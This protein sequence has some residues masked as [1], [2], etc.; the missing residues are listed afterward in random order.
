MPS[1]IAGAAFAPLD[2]QRR[3]DLLRRFAELRSGREKPGRFWRID[4]EAI[5]VPQTAAAYTPPEIRTPAIR[6]G[7]AMDILRAA[8]EHPQLFARAFGSAIAHGDRKFAALAAASCNTGAFVYVPAG[9]AVDEPVEI[10]YDA[11]NGA[12]FPYTLVLAERGS[13]VTI[14]EQVR[15]AQRSFVC[16]IDEVAAGESA[17]VTFA[18][19]QDL[20]D[21]ATLIYTRDASPRKDAG[22]TWSVAHLGAHLTVDSL[23]VH[24]GQPGVEAAINALFF[25]GG[26]QHVDL[27]STATHDAGD[28]RS[29][30]LIKSAGTGSGQG[31]YVGNIRIAAHAQATESG[32]RDDALLLSKHAHIDSVPALEIAANDVK[33]FHGATVGAIDEEQIFYMISRGIAREDAEKMIALGFFEPVVE[34]FPTNAL[35]EMLRRALEAK[36]L[37]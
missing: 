25:P 16:G 21:D 17:A 22:V 23:D 10:V 9:V 19:Y 34:R 1:A 15:G 32:L 5:A 29:Q 26:T 18:A 24:I 4:L 8:K 31:R 7:F 35:R 11:G 37:A 30:T 6:G 2:P 33:A 14:V 20:P 28:S 12:L 3:E 13:R 27:T 36:V